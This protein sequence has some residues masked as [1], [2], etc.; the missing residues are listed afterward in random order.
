MDINNVI[1]MCLKGYKISGKIYI[2]IS[3]KKM[4]LMKESQECEYLLNYNLQNVLFFI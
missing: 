1:T 2:I 3:L 4:F